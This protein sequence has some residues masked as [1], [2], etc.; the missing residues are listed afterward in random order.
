MTTLIVLSPSS[1]L[2]I[3]F[4]LKSLFKKEDKK[5]GEV[6]GAEVFEQTS[7]HSKYVSAQKQRNA[8]I[9]QLFFPDFLKFLLNF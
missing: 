2:C 1:I 9:R 8:E 6:Q 7:V 4:Y 3:L 5:S